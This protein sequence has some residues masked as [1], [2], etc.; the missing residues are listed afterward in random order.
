[1]SSPAA[2]SFLVT[3]GAQVERE[4]FRG[5][6]AAERA[7][8]Y[9]LT[10]VTV[11]LFFAGVYRLYRKYRG[12]GS[13]TADFIARIR[14][15]PALA[16]VASHATIR[17]R[18]GFVGMAHS[19][20]FWG[21]VVLFLGT[22]T[23]AIDEDFVQLLF[24]K[25]AKL[26]VGN[27]YLGFSFL[28]DLAGL[29]FIVGLL[30]LMLRRSLFRP[31]K[32]DYGRNDREDGA[33]E[34]ESY[35]KG[36]AVFLWLLL[37]IAVS[38]FLLEAARIAA[39]LEAAPFEVWSFVGYGLAT[40]LGG[41]LASD[42]AFAG[43]WWFHVVAVFGFLAY[44]PRSKAVHILTDVAALATRDPAAAIVL[45]VLQEDRGIIRRA[46]DFTFR[47]RLAFDACTKCGRCHEAC[48]ARVT[49]APLSPRDLI[50][51]LREKVNHGAGQLEFFGRTRPDVGS[52]QP[53]S[54][55]YIAS[56]TLWSCTTCRACVEACPVG[57]EHVVDIVEMRRALVEEGSLPDSLQ[58]A[59][60]SLDEK[61]NS[62]GESAR[63]RG[64]WTKALDFEVPD[65]TK[66]EVEYLWFVGDFASY[67]AT[68][69][70]GTQ[71]LARILHAAGVSFGLL[72]KA[73]KSAGNDVRRVGEEGL[74]EAL[75]TDNAEA[76]EKARFK[77]IL[78]T[79]PHSFNTLR[80]EYPRLGHNYEVVHYTE[81]LL[82]LIVRGA[83]TLEAAGSRRVT[84]HDPCYL[85]RYNGIY[86]V[87]RQVIA[88]SGA[89]LVEMPRNRDNSF[90]CGA[91]GGRIWMPDP[92]GI[93]ERPSENRI[94]EAVELGVDL[95]V[96][97]CPK[98]MSMFSDAVK[99]TGNE[100]KIRVVDLSELVLDAMSSAEQPQLK[101]AMHG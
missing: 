9:A 45:P 87:P 69:V 81:L 84:Y 65:A 11:A 100:S 46:E 34:R 50:L 74:F 17:R 52:E 98:D 20:V 96:V 1:M 55:G 35:R 32:L 40:A 39:T 6:S 67:N 80:N 47:Q 88:A 54:G 43:L 30:M 48:P 90:C 53:L 94:R 59:L 89:E 101:E 73:E 25:G 85:G 24:G 78:T 26:L 29:A 10:V 18:D 66:E 51:D 97:A 2:I 19:L 21:F 99:T 92:E 8:F 12:S 58:D 16:T 44:L 22:A 38:G 77:K 15:G 13:S 70:T 60:R 5:F 72:Y 57:I 56:E 14:L 28:M 68:A 86:D 71:Q 93:K 33:S 41:A 37:V 64:K 4:V 95:F 3:G 76:L 79:D 49:G 82:E 83:L 31:E 23:I 75:A 27:V 63:K 61:G 91:G 7:G 62:F 36:D 42:G